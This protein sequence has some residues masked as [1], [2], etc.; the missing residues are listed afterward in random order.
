MSEHHA[1]QRKWHEYV[2]TAVAAYR[3]ETNARRPILW[4]LLA[5]VFAGGALSLT[6]GNI[7]VRQGA[8]EVALREIPAPEEFVSALGSQRCTVEPF[9]V[10]ADLGGIGAQEVVMYPPFPGTSF[11]L[12]AGDLPQGVEI[13]FDPKEGVFGS[14]AKL[15]YLVTRSARPGSY[16]VL[17]VYRA[18][19][20]QG[21]MTSVSCQSNLI[22]RR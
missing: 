13:K 15:Q 11:Q 14:R 9:S 8:S 10:S 4:G 7:V 6:Q 1:P 5:L 21:G 16:T 3:H 19:G 12:L 18:R 2:K 22:V 20:A 17:V